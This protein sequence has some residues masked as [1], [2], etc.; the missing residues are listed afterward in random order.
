MK[1]TNLAKKLT[2]MVMTGAMVMS[3]GMTA[4]ADVSTTFDFTKEITTDGNTP[5]PK[6]SFEFKVDS[7]SD[8]ASGVT[9][10][11]TAGPADGLKLVGDGKISFTG[12]EEADADGTYSKTAQLTV[13]ISKFNDDGPGIYSYILSEKDFPEV[14]AGKKDPYEGITKDETQHTL[15][16]YITDEDHDGI[17]EYKGVTTHVLTDDEEEEEKTPTLTFT[18][19]YGKTNNVIHDLTIKKIVD[20][21]QGDTKHPF[22]FKVTINGADGE[23]YKI[24]YGDQDDVIVSGTEKT[25]TLAHNQTFQIYGL[26][27]SDTYT[28]TEY[29]NNDD[30]TGYLTTVSTTGVNTTSDEE[31]LAQTGTV[32]ADNATV[33]YKN[34]KDVPT[35]TGIAMTF[36]PYALMVAFAGVFAVMF[37]RKKREDF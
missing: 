11:V 35:A 32:T 3:M 12:A 34:Y 13:D 24:T 28:V 20:G 22:S 8:S 1:R 14:E 23:N 16:V 5:V 36:A 15:Y 33:D 29:D 6:V 17:L 25:F 21:N 27:E 10:V 9:P 37:L 30:L 7:G 4:F 31:E 18:N 19:D 26:S 2:A